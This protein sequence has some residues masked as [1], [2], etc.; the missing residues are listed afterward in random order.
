MSQPTSRSDSGYAAPAHTQAKQ[1]ELSLR[2]ENSASVEPERDR[3]TGGPRARRA[4][5]GVHPFVFQ[6]G[7]GAVVWFLSVT[8][9]DFAWGRHIDFSLVVVT[10]FFFFFFALLL[11]ASTLIAKDPRWR[12]PKM[13]ITDFLRNDVATNT[14]KMCGRDALIEFA[15]VPVAVAVAATLIGLPWLF[16]H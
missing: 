1:G 13:S 5:T 4:V 11:L 8:W 3:P 15:L 9:L 7:L 16:L 6:L 2:S 14:G 12:Q 10:G